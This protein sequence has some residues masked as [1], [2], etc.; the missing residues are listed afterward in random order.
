MA[1]D[2]SREAVAETVSSISSGNDE[3]LT[4]RHTK[5][6]AE[7]DERARAS[8]ESSYDGPLDRSEM[9]ELTPMEAFKW[10]VEGDQ[11]PCEYEGK[12]WTWHAK[13]TVP[14]S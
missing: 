1:G 5:T 3:G 14:S 4:K 7:A 6:E 2:E 12:Q 13:L 11:S 9:V 8:E 10:N